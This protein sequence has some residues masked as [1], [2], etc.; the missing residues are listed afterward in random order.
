MTENIEVD[1][2]HDDATLDEIE[3]KHDADDTQDPPEMESAPDIEPDTDADPVQSPE[4]EELERQRE[5]DARA[6]REAK[7]RRKNADGET[8]GERVENAIDDA[9]E[10]IERA[11]QQLQQIKQQR[12]QA[13]QR[14]ERL[15]MTRDRLGEQPDDCTVIQTLAGGI[16]ME[17]PPEDGYTK[18]TVSGEEIKV[19]HTSSYDRGDLMDEIAETI[20]ALEGSVDDLGGQEDSLEQALEQTQ[21]AV[22]HL[23][24]TGEI[25]D[26]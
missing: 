2:S 6:K 23:Q 12:Q 5:L 1:L 9:I 13:E 15:E 26:E 18:E 19:S 22:Q 3:H 8:E 7:K 21:M 20:E 24:N 14:I 16:S 4:D 25:L 10:S 11:S 17:V